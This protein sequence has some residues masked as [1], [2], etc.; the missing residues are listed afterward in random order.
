MTP[1][2]YASLFY[3][4][5]L[6]LAGALLFGASFIHL[7]QRQPGSRLIFS[8]SLT[9]FILTAM[10]AVVGYLHTN[11]LDPASPRS[12]Q[13][14]VWFSHS[15]NLLSSLCVLALAMG[16]YRLG[17]HW[18]TLCRECEELEESTFRLA[19]EREQTR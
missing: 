9:L 8:A 12:I 15:R 4:I 10:G 14:S 3:G 13:F 6:A 16:L 19:A 7:G 5:R 2:L 1:L 17:R 11:L 18:P